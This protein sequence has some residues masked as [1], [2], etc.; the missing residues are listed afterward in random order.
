MSEPRIVRK[1]ARDVVPYYHAIWCS[2][3]GGEPFA[4]TV[5]LFRWSPDGEEITLMLGTF[6]FLSAGADEEIDTV[7]VVPSGHGEPYF[8]KIMQKHR[9][10]MVRPITEKDIAWMMAL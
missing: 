8:E 1:K 6:N 7:E 2:V 10:D 5:E 9:E 3:G 4:N